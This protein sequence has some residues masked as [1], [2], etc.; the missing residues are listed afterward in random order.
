MPGVRAGDHQATGLAVYLVR[1]PRVS[2]VRIPRA[3]RTHRWAP[4]HRTVAHGPDDTGRSGG[5]GPRV[6]PVYGDLD[7]ITMREAT[8]ELV[9]TAFGLTHN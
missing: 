6:G 8:G 5:G 9:R 1:S 7:G 4:A 3:V 2:S